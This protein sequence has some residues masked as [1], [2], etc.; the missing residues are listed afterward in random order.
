MEDDSF[1]LSVPFDR[2]L[3]VLGGNE[4]A[5]P[6]ERSDYLFPLLSRWL[7]RFTVRETSKVTTNNTKWNLELFSSC[8]GQW[9]Q[10]NSCTEKCERVN[11]SRNVLSASAVWS[12]VHLNTTQGYAWYFWFSVWNVVLTIW[13]QW[14]PHAASKF[15]FETVSFHVYVADMSRKDELS[16]FCAF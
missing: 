5:M 16:F 12:V 7:A 8:R 10:R 4:D 9:E 14:H 3:L 1:L 2:C 6:A 13:D 15:G 11:C